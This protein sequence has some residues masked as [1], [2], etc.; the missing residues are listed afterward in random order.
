MT[1]ISWS[2][3]VEGNGLATTEYDW[4]WSSTPQIFSIG[5]SPQLILSASSEPRLVSYRADAP[6]TTKLKIWR[7]APIS[8][9]HELD[10]SG[11]HNISD[12]R[13]ISKLSVATTAGTADIIVNTA[14]RIII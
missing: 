10:S 5:T 8:G 6:A 1:T 13:L 2:Q 9:T 4:D 12:W 7:N 14:T 11:G 3:P